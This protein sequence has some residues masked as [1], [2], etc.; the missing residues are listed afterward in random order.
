LI[1]NVFRDYDPLVG[2]YIEPDPSGL[3][4]SWNAYVYADGDPVAAVD[5]LGLYTVAP[6]VPTPSP[7]I[8]ALLN[9]IESKTGLNLTV[10]STSRI[11][12]VHPAGTPHANGVA[13]DVAY[14]ANPSDAARIL[15]AAG[16][17]GA[18]FALDEKLHPSKNSTGPHIHLQIPKG[19][20]GGRG[21]LPAT[22]CGSSQCTS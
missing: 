4:E 9:C 16:G 19:T 7:V 5:P 12:S 20:K 15:C 22:S 17:C 10:T 8:Q 6:G 14:P 18:G 21:D 3:E 13:V 1:Q 2:K 11:S